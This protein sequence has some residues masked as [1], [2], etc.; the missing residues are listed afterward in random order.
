LEGK[1]RGSGRSAYEKH[2]KKKKRVFATRQDTGNWALFYKTKGGAT[3][4]SDPRNQCGPRNTIP[5]Q[6]KKR[7]AKAFPNVFGGEIW[8]PQKKGNGLLPFRPGFGEKG[9]KNKTRKMVSCLGG[10]GREKIL[11]EKKKKSPHPASLGKRWKKKKAFPPDH[12]SSREGNLEEKKKETPIHS[13][14]RHLGHLT[15]L[16]NKKTF[17]KKGKPRVRRDAGEEKKGPPSGLLEPSAG[18]EKKAAA[19]KQHSR[20]GTAL[21]GKAVPSRPN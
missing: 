7:K 17:L 19:G 18:R 14:T 10:G 11:G 12:V 2:K 9:G 5:R 15:G 4:L 20:V 13:R 3:W 1:K 16:P 6:W 8:E 21:I